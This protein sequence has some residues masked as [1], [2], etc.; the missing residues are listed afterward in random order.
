MPLITTS[1]LVRTCHQNHS[2][3]YPCLEC[4]NTDTLSNRAPQE[5]GTPLS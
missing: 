1:I 4:A 2:Y 3:T 5:R